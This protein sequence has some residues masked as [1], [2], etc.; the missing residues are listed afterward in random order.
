MTDTWKNNFIVNVIKNAMAECVFAQCTYI[1]E[2]HTNN[3]SSH[4]LY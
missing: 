3:L 1:I 2:Y 4:S